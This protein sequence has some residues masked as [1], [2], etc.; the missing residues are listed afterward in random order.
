M[1]VSIRNHIKMECIAHKKEISQAFRNVRNLSYSEKQ[2]PLLDEAKVNAFLD[3]IIEF[4]TLLAKK[5]AEIYAVNGRM[6]KLTWLKDLDHE[7]LMLMNDLI[8]LAGDL[9]RSLIRQYIALKNIRAKGIA[10]NEIKDFK[11]A[12][13]ELRETYTDLESVFFFLPQMPDFV[14][15]T[16]KLSLV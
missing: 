9:H 15:T 8:S 6:E 5:T 10:K 16:K 12:I 13:D 1:V 2:S 14:E 11:N 7:C 3:T 4:K